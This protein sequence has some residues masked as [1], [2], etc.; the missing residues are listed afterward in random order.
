MKNYTYD[1]LIKSGYKIENALIAKVDLS[2]A[3]HGCLT[4]SMTLDGGGWGVV[5]G[6]YCLGKGYLGADDDFFEGSAAG[7]E[8]LIRIMDTVG[9]ERF[10]D[11]KGKYVRVATKG[12]G[13]SVKIIGN[14]IKDQWFDAETFFTDKKEN[15]S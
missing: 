7:M 5:Y 14:I 6:G 8:Y 13:G 4:L 1:E 9:V 10:Q 11:L 2:M 12:W 15:K 3:D